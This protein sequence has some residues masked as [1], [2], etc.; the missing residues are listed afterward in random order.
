MKSLATEILH[1]VKKKAT[2]WK[3]ATIVTFVIAVVEL[4]V[5]MMM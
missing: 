1:E 3:V 5:I 4:V 2:F